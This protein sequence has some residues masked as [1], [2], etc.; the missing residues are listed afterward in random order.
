MTD[1]TSTS[2]KSISD[3]RKEA[4]ESFCATLLRL[5]REEAVADLASYIAGFRQTSPVAL[6]VASPATEKPVKAKA[7]PKAKAAPKAVAKA[8]GAKRSR[9]DLEAVKSRILDFL[10]TSPGSKTEVIGP[11][12]GLETKDL[13]LPMR[14]LVAAGTV[15]VKGQKR[16]TEYSV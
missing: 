1:T 16:A 10:K 14:Q 8:S 13:A 7:K 2:P 6:T 11:A 15:K 9:E 3:Q 12:L 5:A 4:C